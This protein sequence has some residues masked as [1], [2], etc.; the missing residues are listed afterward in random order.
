MRRFLCALWAGLAGCA[1]MNPQVLKSAGT[2]G[3]RLALK[4]PVAKKCQESGLKHCD[5]ITEGILLYV[6]AKPADGREHLRVA[7][8]ANAPE[9]LQAFSV[10]ISSLG[11]VPGMAQSMGPVLEAARFLDGSDGAVVVRP[12]VYTS[13]DSSR[14][15]SEKAGPWRMEERD[16]SDPDSLDGGL[17]SPGLGGVVMPCAAA[18]V[19]GKCVTARADP[20]WSPI[21]MPP[22]PATERRWS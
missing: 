16:A 22:A 6:E 11:D 21:F 2:L 7:A 17:S 14:T 5:E 1:G 3:A 4:D 10:M 15:A 12:A 20:S 18:G 9:R 19:L 8:A 13:S